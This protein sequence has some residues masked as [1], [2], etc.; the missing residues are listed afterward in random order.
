[1][2]TKE[3]AW[4]EQQAQ[5]GFAHAAVAGCSARAFL[6]ACSCTQRQLCCLR[7][8]LELMVMATP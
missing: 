1:M 3:L 5:V 7:V 4:A 2:L 8:Q 6:G